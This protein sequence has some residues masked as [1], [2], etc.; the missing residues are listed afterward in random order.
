MCLPLLRFCVKVLKGIVIFVCLFIC[1][2][3]KWEAVG[4][5]CHFILCS[6]LSLFLV[7][8]GVEEI[9]SI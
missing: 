3:I 1:F 4:R 8:E 7:S 2:M 5:G 6:C 9:F